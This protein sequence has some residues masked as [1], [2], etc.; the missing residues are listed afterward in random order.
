[1]KKTVNQK[2]IRLMARQS[3]LSQNYINQ[4]LKIQEK[5]EAIV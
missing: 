4:I 2:E 5:G 3:M 1:M